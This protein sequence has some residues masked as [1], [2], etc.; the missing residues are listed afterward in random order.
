MHS[1]TDNK[2]LE[3]EA[4]AKDFQNLLSKLTIFPEKEESI[5]LAIKQQINEEKYTNDISNKI[6]ES[7]SNIL[8]N[9]NAFGI[10]QSGISELDLYQSNEVC[11][12][13]TKLIEELILFLNNEEILYSN[14][15][16][17]KL[18]NEKN[19]YNQMHHIIYS[20]IAPETTNENLSQ[21]NEI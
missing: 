17:R 18:E 9:Y 7:I 8:L 19:I 5:I 16:I 6:N 10:N 20:L 13:A 21:T 12:N 14:N 4:K 11:A 1:T 15:L 2:A 3:M